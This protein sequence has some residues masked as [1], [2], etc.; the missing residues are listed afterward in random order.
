MIDWARLN[1]ESLAADALTAVCR[2]DEQSFV[3]LVVNF[4]GQI[5]NQVTLVPNELPL[6]V[7]FI[8]E[9]QNSTPIETKKVRFTSEGGFVME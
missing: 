7:D 4:I 5:A 3:Q 2:R 9:L 8:Q 1:W 6:D